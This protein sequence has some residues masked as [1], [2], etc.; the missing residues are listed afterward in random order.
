M[1]FIGYDPNI[2]LGALGSFWTTV[3]EDKDLLRTIVGASELNIAN[4]Y[5][6]FCEIVLGESIHDMPVFNRQN[7][8]NLVFK[9]SEAN[10][11]IGSAILYGDDDV[12]YGD[13]YAYG[14]RYPDTTYSFALP[15]NMVSV[16]DFLCNK[17]YN[18][19]LI[20]NKYEDYFVTNSVVHFTDDLFDN[21]LVP[22]REIVDSNG[23]VTD[24]EISLWA[25]VA[26]FDREYL[27]ERYGALAGIY[28]KSSEEYKTLL[29]N[30][31]AM[32]FMGP[33]K[34]TI[35]G[36]LNQIFGLPVIMEDNETVNYISRTEED[37]TVYTDKNTYNISPAANFCVDICI[38]TTL[39]QFEPLCNAIEYLEDETH[40]GWW[41]NRLYFTIPEK[42]LS[43]Q[44]LSPVTVPNEVVYLPIAVGSQTK[45]GMKGEFTESLREEIEG[46]TVHLGLD[47]EVGQEEMYLNTLDLIVGQ[48]K[49]NIFGIKVDP[50]KVDS[51][52][53]GSELFGIFNRVLP[54]QT[55]YILLLEISSL[56]DEYNIDDVTSEIDL[57]SGWTLSDTILTEVDVKD[58]YWG[59]IGID[60][61]F[62]VGDDVEVGQMVYS[63]YPYIQVEIQDA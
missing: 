30:I 36:Y 49:D 53:I 3:F 24:R 41:K 27:W 46:Y 11:N 19:S 9:E 43:G 34:R 62:A 5:L 18:P 25:P 37:V 8:V 23:N 54:V 31:F 60:G 59:V 45:L 61:Y 40:P 2:F 28:R 14:G 58:G 21:E 33:K 6:R 51:S 17:I 50:T 29:K 16:G 12:D 22:I 57:A 26:H 10:E 48:L 38:G 13:G 47:F 44:Y 15:S 4:D 63:G 35:V 56:E 39:K 32:F 20:L 55:S 7:W 52:V 42:L 1:S